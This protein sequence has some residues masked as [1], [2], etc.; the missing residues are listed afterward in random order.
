MGILSVDLV[1]TNLDYVNSDEDDP[2]VII[3]VRHKSCKKDISKEL[4]TSALNPAR[5]WDW[6]M[7]ED[8]KKRN[9]SN[10]N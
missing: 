8:K 5:W 4:I 7:L 9:K 3:H 1:K 2:K 6:C 10:F